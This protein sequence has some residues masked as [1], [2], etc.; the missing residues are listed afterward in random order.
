MTNTTPVQIP[1]IQAWITEEAPA[2]PAAPKMPAKYSA[3]THDRDYII[4][5]GVHGLPVGTC[6]QAVAGTN[7]A[8]VNFFRVLTVLHMGNGTLPDC[9]AAVKAEVDEDNGYYD[10]DANLLEE[11]RATGYVSNIE[12]EYEG[13]TTPVELLDLVEQDEAIAPVE[14]PVKQKRKRRSKAEIE[15][16][17][18]AN[19]QA[20]VE[21][22]EPCTNPI[23]EAVINLRATPAEEICQVSE[24]SIYARLDAYIHVHNELVKAGIEPLLDTIRLILEF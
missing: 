20:Y 18:E 9:V 7:A 13:A 11:P 2:N 1:S 6:I 15:A 12:P 24:P 21:A 23:I 8:G 4:V 3:F 16:D 22:G 19:S 10:E 14:E 17:N 5:Y